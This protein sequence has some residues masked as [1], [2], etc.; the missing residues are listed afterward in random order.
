MKNGVDIDLMCKIRMNLLLHFVCRIWNNLNMLYIFIE[1]VNYPKMTLISCIEVERK[2]K[3][4]I[5]FGMR[6]Q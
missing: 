1:M 2:K 5:N 3:L 4:F 6:F